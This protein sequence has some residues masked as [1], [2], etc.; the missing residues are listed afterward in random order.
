MITLA[1]KISSYQIS[2]SKAQRNQTARSS[3]SKDDSECPVLARKQCILGFADAIH[4]SYRCC[5]GRHLH[6]AQK[7][8]F[9]LS[10]RWRVELDNQ[11]IGCALAIASDSFCEVSKGATKLSA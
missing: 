1:T 4:A 9:R 7:R 2:R 10:R 6:R 8:L 11:R 5:V 3:R